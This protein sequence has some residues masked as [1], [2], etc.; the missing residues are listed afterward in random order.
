MRRCASV[1][2]L[3]GGLGITIAPSVSAQQPIAGAA[4]QSM[5]AAAE[6]GVILPASAASAPAS[7]PRAGA[8]PADTAPPPAGKEDAAAAPAR[9]E[10]RA[11]AP[12]RPGFADASDVVGAGAAQIEVGYVR[13]FDAVGGE[14]TRATAMPQPVLRLG[15]SDRFEVNFASDGWTA[16]GVSA[17][18]EHTA[19]ANDLVAG[20]KMRVF[21][22]STA[23]VALAVAGALSIPS[24]AAG[25]SSGRYDPAVKINWSRSLPGDRS[26][27]GGLNL[28]WVGDDAGV[29]YLQRGASVSVGQS[30]GRGWGTFAEV[31]GV[32][33]G[34][35]TAGR[36]LGA[37][38]GLTKVVGENVQVDVSI[39]RGLTGPATDWV[40]GG[41]FVIRTVR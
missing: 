29:R 17:R 22:E 35:H 24:G 25:I 31:F 26:L 27:S 5:A 8:S 40:V 37:G 32:F 15:L 9:R 21:E 14:A 3:V 13:E 36:E 38:A 33:C 20:A 30:F 6:S 12:D 34:L 4:P 41:G 1:L 23:G 2:V 16:T 10:L 39:G 28:L 11:L 19:G 7:D 18:T